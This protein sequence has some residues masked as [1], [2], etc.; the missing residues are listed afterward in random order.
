MG[1]ITNN[2]AANNSDT[3]LQAATGTTTTSSDLVHTLAPSPAEEIRAWRKSMVNCEYNGVYKDLFEQL[4]LYKK[5]CKETADFLE[6]P[7]GLRLFKTPLT[8]NVNH[9][10]SKDNVTEVSWPD[11][12]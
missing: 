3:A 11:Y 2:S 9:P 12:T 7:N 6:L 4:V 5:N 10:H 8:M 1:D